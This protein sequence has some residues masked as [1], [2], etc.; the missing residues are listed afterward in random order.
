VKVDYRLVASETG[1]KVTVDADVVLSGAAAQF[2]R[3][4][5]IK[6]M[7]GRLIGDFVHCLESKLA[8]PTKEAAAEVQAG[9]VRGFSLFVS[10]LWAR[11]VAWFKRL[12]GRDNH[13]E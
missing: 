7:S 11:V 9:E 10:S 2:G 1:T 4:G 6:E 12:V 5:L 13:A 3:T 8:A